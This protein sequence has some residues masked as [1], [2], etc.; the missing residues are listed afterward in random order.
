MQDHSRT[1]NKTKSV[2]GI[3]GTRKR[4]NTSTN[5]PW[6]RLSC[7]HLMWTTLCNTRKVVIDSHCW[8]IIACFNQITDI[9]DLFD[10]AD[11]SWDLR[12]FVIWSSVGWYFLNNDSA[13][14]IGPIFK[15]Q[16][17]QGLVKQSTASTAYF[18]R[19][20]GYVLPKLRY[21]SNFRR[22]IKSQNS[23]GLIYTAAEAWNHAEAEA[24]ERPNFIWYFVS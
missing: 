3:G 20:D 14:P 2:K 6:C 24:I 21:E 7:I 4:L 16:V 9:K 22:C 19:W 15:G 23:P 11:R 18:W 12:S 13:Q 10:E 1:S 17:F 8:N 5:R